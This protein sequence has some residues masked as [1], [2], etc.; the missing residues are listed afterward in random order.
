MKILFTHDYD[1]RHTTGGAELNLRYAYDNAPNGVELSFLD[2][3]LLTKR[4]MRGFDK[5]I[6]GNS[7]RISIPKIKM[8]VRI[9]KELK[10][11]YIKSEHD[12]MWSD[13]RGAPELM[14]FKPM[15]YDVVG[16]WTKNDWYEPTK[17][18]FENAE[19]VRF[20]SPKQELIF[21]AVDIIPSNSFIA[22]SYVD[23]SIFQ[24]Y[25]DWEKRPF[26]A[27]CKYGDFWGEAEGKR[28]A[29][30]DGIDIRVLGHRGL[31][32]VG[33]ADF[34]NSYKYFYDYPEMMTTYGRAVLEAYLCGVKLRVIENHAIFS[35][36]TM[37]DAVE[38]SQ[39][40]IKDFWNGVL[41]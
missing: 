3:S 35:F 1:F 8:L 36:G 7:R 37:D 41:R 16:D 26:E 10:I 22:G 39:N 2:N 6:M 19:M 23:K 34:Y 28:R 31:D 14:F 15:E 13:D 12:V 4:R 32:A 25:V 21:S 38:N 17:L 27:F 29:K 20:L 9:L 30:A 40:A 33:M 11:P 18:L 5:V 24:N